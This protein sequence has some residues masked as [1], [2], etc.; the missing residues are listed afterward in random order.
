MVE[1]EDV[2]A[3]I[4]ARR[5]LGEEMEPQVIDAFLERV[6]QR[7]EKR[8]PAQPAPH[9]TVT[10]LAIGS[11]FAGVAAT[12]AAL[13]PTDGGAGGIIVAVIAWIAIAIV[14][15]AYARRR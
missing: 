9:W 4:E 1:R 14:N 12:G 8:A 11:L 2:Q 6:E 13:G 5:E 3:A 7:L 15:V 10:P